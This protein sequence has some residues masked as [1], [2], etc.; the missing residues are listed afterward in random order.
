MNVLIYDTTL[1]D[2]TQGE[3]IQMSVADKMTVARLLDDLGVAYIEG[4]WPFSNP[5]DQSFFEHCRQLRL[6]RARLTAF[7]STRRPGISCEKDPNLQALVGTGLGTFCIFGKAWTFQVTDALGVSLGENLELIEQSVR[8]LKQHADQV[9][10]DAEHY[11]DGFADNP[12]YALQTL[13]AAQAGGAD[14]IVLC[15][16]NGG[17]LPDQVTRACERARGAVSTPLGIHTHNDGELAVANSLAA[18]RAGA[19]MVQGTINGY[20]ERC[21]NANLVSIIPAL[22]LKMG[23][24]CL[25]ADRLVRLADVSHALDEVTNRAPLN[26]QPYVGRSAFAHKA[27]MHVNAVN[28]DS[29]TYEHVDPALVGNRRRILVSDL[30]GR[31]NIRLKARQLG[32]ELDAN[33]PE[34]K[35]VLARLK[36]LESYG[37]QFEGA[38]ASFK[39]MVDEALGKRPRYFELRDLEVTVG[40]GDK[41]DDSALWQG[42]AVASIEVDVGGIVA[43]TKAVGEGPVHAM[44]VGL[45]SLIDKFYPTLKSV[46]LIDYKVRVLGSKQGTGSVVRV[47]L[48][49]GDGEQVWETVGVSPNIIA[50]SWQAMVDALEYKLVKDGVEAH[51]REPETVSG[52]PG[53]AARTR[54]SRSQKRKRGAVNNDRPRKRTDKRTP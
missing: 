12:D 36:E 1:R 34:T 31:D 51:S 52:R 24:G 2:G 46:R 47:L 5:R 42:D 4:G 29:R 3:G 43:R 44:D 21:G 37:Y 33:A 19:S 17:A 10:F 23:V 45:R 8:Y 41:E 54:A 25:P 20:G 6:Q 11:F 27:G 13:E 30:S 14:Y 15:D 9:I 39:L 49:S 7:G 50:A 38:A 16:T 35:Q 48:Q 32:I 40:L 53:S 26:N 28:K 22:M 18:V